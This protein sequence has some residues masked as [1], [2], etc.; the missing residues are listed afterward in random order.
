MTAR[1]EFGPYGHLILADWRN[2]RAWVTLTLRSGVQLSGQVGQRQVGTDTVN[3]VNR[4]GGTE[5]KHDVLLSE[6]AAITA[7]AR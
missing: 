2:C 4:D 1:E 6:V 7:E 5:V 3:L